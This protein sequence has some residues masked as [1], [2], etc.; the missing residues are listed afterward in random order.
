MEDAYEVYGIEEGV[1][2]YFISSA[3]LVS[4]PSMPSSLKIYKFLD[5]ERVRETGQPPAFLQVGEWLYPLVPG[6]SPAL[7]SNDGAY[8]FPDCEST[9]QGAC[10]GIVV[11]PNLSSA[12]LRNFQETIRELTALRDQ[13]TE[14]SREA[15][16][17]SSVTPSERT[18]PAS[19]KEETM[20]VEDEE[21][22]QG[23]S[24]TI[25]KGIETGA[26]WLS[27][28]LGKGATAGGHLLSKGADKLKRHIRPVE[29]PKEFD[30]KY[31]KGA[32]Y[33]RKVTGGVVTVSGVVIDGLCYMTTKL[34]EVAAPVIRE[35]TDKLIKKGD[36]GQKNGKWSKAFNGAAEVAVSGI[37][38]IGVVYT[39]LE[40]AAKTWQRVYIALRLM[41]FQHR[42][43]DPAAKLT[44]NSM[45]T[46]GN[47]G[48]SVYN[49]KHL[50]VKAIAKRTAKDTGKALAKEYPREP[51]NIKSGA[52]NSDLNPS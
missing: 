26:S 25:A 33:A 30:E 14:S 43:G 19:A 16:R 39:G 3:G 40:T 22:G 27:W 18:R 11:P 23:I 28:G 35:Q 52:N 15:E 20:E 31:Q 1:Q 38:G 50:G 12:K 7:R 6:Q 46:V 42:Y 44:D 48:V 32:H 8:I 29:D 36:G 41:L 21:K 5:E 4:P 45:A 37:T 9:D 51:G 10:V 17:A 49:F 24:T 47:V 13:S 34:G 2:I